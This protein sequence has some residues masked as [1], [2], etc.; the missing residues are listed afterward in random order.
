MIGVGGFLGIGERN[1]AV[2]YNDLQWSMTPVGRTAN[3]SNT[4]AGGSP[5]AT[6]PSGSGT[7][8]PV[9]LGTPPTPGSAPVNTPVTNPTPARTNADADNRP[10]A[11]PDHAVL[12]NASKDQL[13]NAPEFKY[14]E[15]PR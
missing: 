7:T 4:N 14:G 9:A 13:Q 11:Y 6:G 5:R 1:V 8:S 3:A 12:A 15:A 2:P 10:A